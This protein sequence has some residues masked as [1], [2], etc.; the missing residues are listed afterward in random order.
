LVI[1]SILGSNWDSMRF[2]EKQFAS[3]HYQIPLERLIFSMAANRALHPFSNFQIGIK[4]FIKL[5]S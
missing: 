5:L 3:H 4:T 1:A 2:S